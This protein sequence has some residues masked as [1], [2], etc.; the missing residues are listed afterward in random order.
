M[1]SRWLPGFARRA[2]RLALSR[3]ARLDAWAE[4]RRR[5]GG[6]PDLPS[7]R[8]EHVL[9]VCHGNIC[10]SPFAG[11]LLSARRP[12]LRVRTAG[13]EAREGAPA[14]AQAVTAARAFGADLSRHAAHCLTE[15]D[16]AWA[17]LLLAMEGH[18]AARLAREAAEARHKTRLLGDFLPSA[19][20]AIPDPWGRDD[21]FFRAVF[22]RIAE[23]TDAL[24]RA[25][26]GRRS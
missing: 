9:V 23:A 11:A 24:C 16:L 6:E 1:G 19:P 18:Q 7:G 22:Q 20:F 14:E 3:P 4:W 15:D 10:R 5:L 13:F 26:Q 12:A 25:L 2:G 21:A 8:L 17:D